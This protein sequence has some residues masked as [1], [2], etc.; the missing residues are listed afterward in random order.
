[1]DLM[2][3]IF[4]HGRESVVRNSRGQTLSEYSLIFAAIVILAFGGYHALGNNIGSLANSINYSL[5]SA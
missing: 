4:I 5:T 3:K 1:M 2:T